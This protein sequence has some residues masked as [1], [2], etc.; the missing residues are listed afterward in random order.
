MSRCDDITTVVPRYRDPERAQ[1]KIDAIERVLAERGAIPE[2][3][4]V[5]AGASGERT[6]YRLP[7]GRRVHSKRIR[8]VRLP[9]TCAGCRFNNDRD[10]HEGFYV[11]RLHYDRAGRH[12]VG[13]CIQRRGPVRSARGVPDRISAAD[14][15]PPRKDPANVDRSRRVDLRGELGTPVPVSPPPYPPTVPDFT[16]LAATLLVLDQ[17]CYALKLLPPYPGS[18]PDES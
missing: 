1:R 8:R 18:Q 6:A 12:R 9:D 5:T 2:A 14:S 13:V 15:P 11:V 3:R 10:R 7:D 4:H 16:D 17:L